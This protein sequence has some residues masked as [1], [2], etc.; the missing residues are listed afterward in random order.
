MFGVVGAL[1]FLAGL[2]AKRQT[3]L[4]YGQISLIIAALGA[5]AAFLTGREAEEHTEKVWYMQRKVV[6]EHEESGEAAMIV[7]IV[8]GVL[9]AAS[10]KQWSPRNQK[11][12]YALVAVASLMAGAAM[13]KTGFEGGKIVHGNEKL[14]APPQSSALPQ[15]PQ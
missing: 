7:M 11:I 12:L 9:A 8:T 1:F 5:P 15:S 3:L 6:H 14:N 13:V 4:R 2:I 10:L